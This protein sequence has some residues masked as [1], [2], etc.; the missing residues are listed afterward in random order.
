MSL[1]KLQ[2]VMVFFQEREHPIV[3]E[4]MKDQKLV[5]KEKCKYKIKYVFNVNNQAIKNLQNI[6]SYFKAGLCVS[7]DTVSFGDF[8]ESS[9]TYEVTV[10]KEGW[11]EAPSGFLAR[12]SYRAKIQFTGN[13]QNVN[14]EVPYSVEIKNAWE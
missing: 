14:F 13:E 10:P 1:F 5:L 4:D 6:T 7:K 3:F 8:N 9:S 2:K 11:N 12:G